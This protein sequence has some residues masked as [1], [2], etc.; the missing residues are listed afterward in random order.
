[1]RHFASQSPYRT[2][3]K[4]VERQLSRGDPDKIRGTYNKAMYLEP[5]RKMTQDWADF[6]E[7]MRSGRIQPGKFGKAAR[8]SF[9]FFRVRQVMTRLKV[10]SEFG[11]ST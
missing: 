1:L 5:R 2:S 3:A 7:A 11:E 4:W 6:L 8:F 9:P 10:V